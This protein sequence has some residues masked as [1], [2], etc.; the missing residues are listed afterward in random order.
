AGDAD[1]H[2]GEPVMDGDKVVGV[3]TSGGY[4]HT[5]GKSLCFAYVEPG[6]AKLG[7]RFDIE[8]IGERRKAT[9]LAE[10][11]FDPKNEALRG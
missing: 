1:V 11:A 3:T 4:G 10:P 2:G 7:A 8:I 9:V 6:Y 5:V